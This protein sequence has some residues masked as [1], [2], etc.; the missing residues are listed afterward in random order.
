MCVESKLANQ[1][2]SYL[3]TEALAEFAF[4][5]VLAVIAQIDSALASLRQH[6]I[7]G[8]HHCPSHNCN[9]LCKQVSQSGF[10]YLRPYNICIIMPEYDCKIL[11]GGA[12]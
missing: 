11:N 7:V 1:P 3:I 12:T 10:K 2:C 8:S 6:G 5:G 4:L 9:V